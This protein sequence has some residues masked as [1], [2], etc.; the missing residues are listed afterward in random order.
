MRFLVEHALPA[1]TTRED[2]EEAQKAAM[3]DK[4]VRGYRSFLNLTENKGYCIFDAP[5]Q[6]HLV[7]WLTQHEHQ[8]DNIVEV[9]LEGE[10]GRWVELPAPVG[11]A[12]P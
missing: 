11:A 10:H 4:D 1:G 8:Y 9:E 2:I 7:K 5:S 3:A 6:E 12:N